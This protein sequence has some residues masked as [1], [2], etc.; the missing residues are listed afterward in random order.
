MTETHRPEHALVLVVEDDPI[1]MLSLVDFVENAGCEAIEADSVADAI[2][3]LETRPDIRTVF[4]DLDM[5][6]STAGMELA[7]SIRDRWPP[8]E[9]LM[10]SSKPWD[11]SQIPARGI[12]LGKPF[13]RRRIVAAIQK[14]AA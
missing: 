13:D 3:I 9:L 5:R 14:F 7:L 4:T 10:V 8:I 2:R 12:V 1:L 11:A 6:G